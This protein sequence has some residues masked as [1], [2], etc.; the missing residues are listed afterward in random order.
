MI[1]EEHSLK[2]VADKLVERLHI[3]HIYAFAVRWIGDQHSGHTV[4]GGSV[5]LLERLDAEV[6]IFVNTCRED[7]ALGY[8]DSFGRDVSSIYFERHFAAFGILVEDFLK[9]L[10]VIVMP[11]FEC[12]IFAEAAGLDVCCYHGSLDE[13]CA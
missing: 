1:A 13:E 8:G 10:A 11:V 6:D 3:F 4:G 7:I 12:E 2:L 5:P 9:Q